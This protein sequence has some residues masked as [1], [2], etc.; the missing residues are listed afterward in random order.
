ML[1]MTGFLKCIMERNQS[2]MALY[3]PASGKV[4]YENAKGGTLYAIA[5]AWPEN[6][7]LIV[8]PLASGSS[9]NQRKIRRVQL[10]GYTGKLKW[11]QTAE[12]LSIYLPSAK[13]GNYALSI[14]VSPVD[15]AP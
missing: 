3:S 10:L 6:G 12:G 4:I 13:P 14:K 15:R 8:K 1:D 9:L 7:K 5:L 11:S 2:Q